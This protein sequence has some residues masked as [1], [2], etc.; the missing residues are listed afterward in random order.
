MLF[1]T[2]RDKTLVDS[3]TSVSSTES[4]SAEYVSEIDILNKPVKA[5]LS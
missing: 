1:V 4:C 3:Q 2:E 5:Y